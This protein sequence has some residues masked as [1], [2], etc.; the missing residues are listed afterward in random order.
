M[1]PFIFVSNEY[2]HNNENW[3]EGAGIISVEARGFHGIFAARVPFIPGFLSDDFTRRSRTEERNQ[4]IV[5]RQ[6]RFI[7]DLANATQHGATFDL[8][9]VTTPHPTISGRSDIEIF[10]L[11]KVFHRDERNVGKIALDLWRKVEAHFPSEDPYNYPLEPVTEEA[12]FH[13]CFDPIPLEGLKPKQLVEVRKYL[14][15]D[16]YL[17]DHSFA[18]FF[19][20]PFLPNLKFSALGGLMEAMANQTEK[21]VVSISLKPAKMFKGESQALM[22]MLNNY[23]TMTD[24]SEGWLTLHRKERSEDLWNT[25]WPLIN[26]RN[27]LF[28]IKV[29]VL[30]AKEAPGEV[31][32]TLGSEFMDNTTDEPRLWS[33]VSPGNQQELETAANNFKFLEHNM[34]GKTHTDAKSNRL[35]F[36]VSAYEAAGAFRLPIPPESGYMPGLIIRDEAFVLPSTAQYS[37]NGNDVAEAEPTVEL[38]E[39]IHRG[40]RTGIPFN[41]SLQELK[42]H[43]LVGGATGSGK[44]NTCLHL[45]SQL[46]RDYRIPF[47]VLYPIDKPDYRLLMADP[48]VRDDLLVFTLGDETVS[49]FRFNPFFVPPGIL[50]KTHISQLMRCFSAAFTLWDPLPAVYREALYRVYEDH[51]W[52]LTSGKGGDSGTSTPTMGDFYD[53]LIRAASNLTSK[54]GG[55]VKGNIRQAT[56]I[57]MRDLLQNTGSIINVS[58]EVS[59]TEILSRPTVMELGR[60]GSS[61]DIALIMGFLLTGLVEE[62]QSSQKSLPPTERNRQHITLVEEAHRL[63]SGGHGGGEFRADARAKGGEDFSDILAEV[64]GFGEGIMIAEQMPAYLVAG[65]VG[66]TKFKVMHQLED[67]PSFNLFSE[68]LNLD[69]RQAEYARGLSVGQTVV[70]DVSGQPVHVQVHNYLD[71]FQNPDDRPKIDDSDENVQAFMQDRWN[72]PPATPWQP[73]VWGEACRWCRAKCQHG[74]AVSRIPRTAINEDAQQFGGAAVRG[75]WEEVKELALKRVTKEELGKSA[76]AAYCWVARIAASNS[77]DGRSNFEVYDHVRQALT[78]FH[79]STEQGNE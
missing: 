32:H 47:L 46:W 8:R 16:P 63:M 7:N 5:G 49:P 79:S 45:L 35:P 69:A 4:A 12:D 15:Y 1:T 77:K 26:Q 24:E 21:C 27:H 41:I 14:D 30:G 39:I 36:L 68:V 74:T 67:R 64:R 59:F 65:A 6:V 55:E 70:R 9:F 19:P 44:T 13:R 60:V 52:D 51:G 61:E 38:G 72:L 34:W 71:Q 25:Y 62:L 43:T 50:L 53:Q 28:T 48:A 11:G 56:E 3:Q 58:D 73:P 54:Y 18:G 22:H 20:H 10:L 2:H 40:T 37:K 17:S 31:V 23:A 33:A 76:D 57:R 29:Q 75:D 42:R 66:N 78:N